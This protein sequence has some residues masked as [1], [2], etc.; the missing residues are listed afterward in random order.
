MRGLSVKPLATAAAANALCERILKGE[1]AMVR[2]LT[3]KGPT[4][5]ALTLSVQDTHRGFDWID[6]TFEMNGLNDARLV[7]DRQL[8]FIDTV[9]GI[10]VLFED[11]VWGLGIGRY[12]SL[13]AL[14][15]APLYLVGTSL[16]YEEAPFSG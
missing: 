4:C 12:S 1:E 7:E 11:G 8:S 10:T 14:K 9:E 13:R 3:V 15:S 2:S 16:K 5:A 6:I